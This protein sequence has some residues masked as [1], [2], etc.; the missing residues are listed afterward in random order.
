MFGWAERMPKLRLGTVWLFIGPLKAPDEPDGE[1]AGRRKAEEPGDG[2]H[3]NARHLLY[4]NSPI[5]RF[6][7]PNE[8][9]P[10]EVSAHPACAPSS[11]EGR[12]PVLSPLV[13][14]MAP[15][16]GSLTGLLSAW[17]T[18]FD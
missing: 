8:K 2:Y 4:P 13:S 15:A 18:L 9:V 6:P 5:T 3:V 14:P 7:V 10:W 12:G 11:E 1:L 16:H 17:P